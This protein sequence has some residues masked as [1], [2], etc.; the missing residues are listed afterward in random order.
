MRMSAIVRAARVGVAAA[1]VCAASLA[2]AHPK[3]LSSSPA[4]RSVG[5]AP[6]RIELHFSEKLV[7]QFCDATLVMTGTPGHGPTNIPVKVATS[8]DGKALTLSPAQPL[9][10]GAYRLDWRVVAADTHRVSGNL[11]FQVK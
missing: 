3:L 2:F 4:D 9:T 11:A 1:A 5:A 7:A 10:P 6:E 8:G